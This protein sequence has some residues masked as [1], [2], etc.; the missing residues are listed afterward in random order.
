MVDEIFYF[1]LLLL[2]VI[3]PKDLGA[4]LLNSEDYLVEFVVPDPIQLLPDLQVHLLDHVNDVLH[5][6]LQLLVEQHQLVDFV[7]LPHAFRFQ[8]LQL[9]VLLVDYFHVLLL[10]VLVFLEVLNPLLLLLLDDEHRGLLGVVDLICLEVYVFCEF[11]PPQRNL[12]LRVFF[13][14]FELLGILGFLGLLE[15]FNLRLF[16]LF[17]LLVHFPFQLAHRFFVIQT[18]QLLLVFVDFHLLLH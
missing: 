10:Y 9:F 17:P 4:D 16:L 18:L 11:A 13:Q 2:P 7:V 3:F 5:F 12:E 15:F 14:Y 6:H 1:F 8:F